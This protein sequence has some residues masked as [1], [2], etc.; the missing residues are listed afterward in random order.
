[1]QENISTAICRMNIQGYFEKE[2]GW[3]IGRQAASV[4][5]IGIF[6]KEN[7][8]MYNLCNSKP[9]RMYIF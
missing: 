7:H 2:A 6:Y 5:N 8:F 1:M 3:G 4:V 9:Q